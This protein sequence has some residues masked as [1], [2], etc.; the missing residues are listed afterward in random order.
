M[1]ADK[2]CRRI[3]EAGRQEKQGERE[4]GRQKKQEG[5]RRRQGRE[6]G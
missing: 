6:T 4:P 2:R 3:R 5:K 1:Q